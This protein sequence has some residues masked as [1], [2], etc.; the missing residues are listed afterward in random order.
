MTKRNLGVNG[1]TLGIYLGQMVSAACPSA[2]EITVRDTATVEN[3]SKIGQ[4]AAD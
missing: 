3:F 1:C 4:D 2:S